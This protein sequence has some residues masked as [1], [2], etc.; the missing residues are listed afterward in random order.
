MEEG[1][2]FL[3]HGCKYKIPIQNWKSFL[4]LE[5]I[6]ALMFKSCR[7]FYMKW[8]I[9]YRTCILFFPGGISGEVMY[10]YKTPG[11]DAI[12]P[13]GSASP[14][15]TTCSI[16]GWFFRKDQDHY[17]TEVTS[18]KVQGNSARAARL[19]LN[20][21]CSFVISNITAEDAGV[22]SC[23]QDVHHYVD[24]YLSVLTSESRFHEN[25]LNL[26]PVKH[27]FP[28]HY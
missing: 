12:L 20:P 3:L 8:V 25:S 15:D 4:L 19:S 14:S 23:Y 6:K 7:C 21:D 22:Y 10:L 24:I 2:T 26:F 16:I 11:H 13:C 28:V 5:W 1:A 27:P 9:S 18:G 17:I